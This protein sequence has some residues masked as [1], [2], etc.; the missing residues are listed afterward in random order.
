MHGILRP[1]AGQRSKVKI[2]WAALAVVAALMLAVGGANAAE[3]IRT[4]DIDQAVISK[5]SS[6]YGINSKVIAHV[7]LAK[8]FETKVPWTLVIGKQPDEESTAR[9]GS[10]SPE[11]AVSVCFVQN[12]D[13][14]CSEAILLAKYREQNVNSGLGERPFF[15]FFAGD[16]VYSGPGKTAPLLRIKLCTMPG[17]NGNCGVSTFLFAYDGE[18]DSFRVVFFNSTGRNNNQETRF[19]ETGPLLGAVIVADPYGGAPPPTRAR[20][21]AYSV[22]VY[23]RNV[24]GVYARV[25]AYRGGTSYGDGNPLA[26]IDSEMPETLRR[27]GLWKTGDPL[28][29]PPA[30]PEGC[31]RLVMRKNVEWCEPN[32]SAEPRGS[33]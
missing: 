2:Y 27:S 31:T 33:R 11:G 7:D 15:E 8:P 21:Y 25:L 28:P 17:A 26:V 4:A 16:V 32:N 19:V 13:P 29:V 30:M 9:N 14:D 1:L 10:G 18:A 20:P 23:R 24:A 22:E 3:S 5:L 6:L 12:T